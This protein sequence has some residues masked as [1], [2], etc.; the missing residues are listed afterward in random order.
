MEEEILI[1]GLV[2]VEF[3]VMNYLWEKGSLISKKEIIR[4]IKQMYG[5]HKSTIKIVLKGLICKDFLAREII[6]FQ[7]HYKIIITSEEYDTFNKKV[8]KSTKNRKIIHSLTTI[9]K[10]MSKE[11]LDYLEEYYRNLEE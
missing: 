8:L 5:W 10:P 6:R 7:S 1:E 11:K 4:D 9:H 3:V 2:R